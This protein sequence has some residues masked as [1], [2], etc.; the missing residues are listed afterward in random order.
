MFNQPDVLRHFIIP[1]P[2]K[3]TQLFPRDSPANQ[4]IRDVVKSSKAKADGASGMKNQ[5]YK[6]LETSC[7][8]TKQLLNFWTAIFELDVLQPV[9]HSKL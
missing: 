5:C 2:W 8:W 4:I 9:S 6:Q 3:W 1:E 7:L